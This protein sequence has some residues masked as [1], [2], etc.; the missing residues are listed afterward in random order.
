MAVY[1][2]SKYG[3]EAYGYDLPPAYRVDPFVSMPTDYQTISLSWTQPAGTIQAFRLVRNSYGYPVD[4]DDGDILIDSL[5]YPGSQ[6]KDTDIIPG[7]YYYYGFYVATNLSTFS[8]VRSG[9]TACL[10]IKNFDSYKEMFSLIPEYYV[11]AVG[12]DDVITANT[13]NEA[14]QQFMQVFGWGLDLLRTQYNTYLNLN[15]PWKIPQTQLYNLAIQLGLEINPDIHPITLRKAVLNNATINKHRGTPNGIAT[16]VSSLTGWNIDLQIGSNFM[17]NNDQS[18]FLDPT[19]AS[20]SQ[21]LNYNVGERVSYN[22]GG[23]TYV[24]QCA[25]ASNIGNAPSGSNTNNTWWNVLSST[26]DDTILANSLTGGINTWEVLYPAVSNGAPIASSIHELLGAVNPLDATDLTHNALQGVNHGVGS[27]DIWLRSVSRTIADMATVTTNFATDKYQAV[28]DGIPIPYSLPS[29]VWNATT[30]YKPGQ[31]ITYNNMPFL[32]LRQSKDAVPPYTTPGTATT[33]WTPLSYEPRFRICLSTYSLGSSAI[34]VVPF[35][36]WYD[37]NGNYIARVTSRNPSPGTTG[38]PDVMIFDSFTTNVGGTLSGRNTDDSTGGT[39]T[40]QAGTFSL[41]PVNR[42]STYPLTVGQRTEATI[43]SG[44]SD[45]QVG[46]TLVSDPRHLNSNV[47]FIDGSFAGWTSFQCTSSVQKS[48]DG[49]Y[50][51]EVLYIPG[52]FTASAI[53]ETNSRFSATPT[54]N[55][56]AGAWVY[57]PTGY[58]NVQV[59]FDWYNVSSGYISTSTVNFTVAANTWTFI[60]GNLTAPANTATAAL[61][62]G[63]GGSPTSA[64]TLRIQHAYASDQDTGLILRRTDD[65]HYI[66]AGIADLRT[67]NGGTWTILGTYSQPFAAGDRMAVQLNGTSIVVFRNNVSVLS[68]TSSFN[69]TATNHGMIVENI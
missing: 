60:A 46:L 55:Y 37:A 28:A 45:G 8:W 2:I 59:G 34:Q 22:N 29:Q 68:T 35:V 11:S 57:S 10:A 43:S 31:I 23:N 7:T 5:T 61:R 14:L 1:G 51:R 62:V 53:E 32:A 3:S 33:E 58:N 42:G 40:Q 52:A 24:Y 67:N 13:N 69:Q 41:S 64:N 16:E 18:A 6:F 19:Y 50:I 25:N 17:L 47:D 63:E 48:K 49:P 44:V 54:V 30:T 12:K 39:W 65:T 66:R 26:V 21:Y 9:L 36:E 56:L 38:V 4:Q 27:Q 20:W 15:N